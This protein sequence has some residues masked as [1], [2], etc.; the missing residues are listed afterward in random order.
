MQ[1][2]L[3]SFPGSYTAFTVHTVQYIYAT[4]TWGGV[5]E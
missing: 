1:P 3:A 5:W 2:G 4:K